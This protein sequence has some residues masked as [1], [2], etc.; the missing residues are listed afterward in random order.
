MSKWL[1][2]SF[3]YKVVLA[4]FSAFVGLGA[5]FLLCCW[6]AFK[7]KPVITLGQAVQVGTLLL[8]F[9]WANHVYAKAHDI[10]K[11]RI[12]ILVDMVGDILDQA[13]Q[14]HSIVRKCAGQNP[15]SSDVRLRLDSALTDYSNAVYELDEVLKHSPHIP[16][17]SGVKKLLRGREEYK[18]LITEAPY[19]TS[20]PQERLSQESKLYS[21]IRSDLRSFQ[22]RLTELA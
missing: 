3:V 8:I 17:I 20:L 1:D 2:S 9:Y 5:G 19:P 13:K 10:R 6:E 18:D 14:A 7:F 12:E 4:A 22:L 15:V 21:K 11:K 16:K